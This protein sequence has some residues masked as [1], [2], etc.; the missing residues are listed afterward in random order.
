MSIFEF[1]IGLLNA[2]AWPAAILAVAIIFRSEVAGL[3]KRMRSAEYKGMKF[4]FNDVVKEINKIEKMND[5]EMDKLDKKY[6]INMNPKMIIVGSWIE[7]ERSVRE[8]FKENRLFY[9]RGNIKMMIERLSS[10]SIIDDNEAKLLMDI[11]PVRNSV[12]HGLDYKIDEMS[13]LIMS[14]YLDG[15]TERIT[16]A[17]SS[18]TSLS[19]SH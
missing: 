2:I 17:T 15:L 16:S 4:N 10:T 18:S 8:Y 6:A 13:A 5:I 1:I 11:Y 14:R 19:S 3:F 9:K 7:F 12:V